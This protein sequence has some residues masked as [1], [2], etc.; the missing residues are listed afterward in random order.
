MPQVRFPLLCYLRALLCLHTQGPRLRGQLLSGA[1]CS[2]SDAH[3]LIN[4]KRA[5]EILKWASKHSFEQLG[6]KLLEREMWVLNMVRN[7]HQADTGYLGVVGNHIEQALLTGL[8]WEGSLS[9]PLS[10]WA[11]ELYMASSWPGFQQ[12]KLTITVLASIAYHLLMTPQKAV[13]WGKM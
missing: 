4:G 11:R 5:L 8:Q 3:C 12:P 1:D 10:S 13:L 2:L 7:R 6:V 9:A